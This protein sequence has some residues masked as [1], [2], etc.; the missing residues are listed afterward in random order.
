MNYFTQF[1]K[2]S[3]PTKQKKTASNLFNSIVTNYIEPEN[4]KT[5][6]NKIYNR[7]D[8]FFQHVS[9]EILASDC[10]N[11]YRHNLLY[12]VEEGWK[13]EKSKTTITSKFLQTNL[14]DTNANC[15]MKKKYEIHEHTNVRQFCIDR[16]LSNLYK[17]STKIY[18]IITN[19]V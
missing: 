15:K 16:L 2:L 17:C 11:K 14:G 3:R 19:Y 7:I 6:F 12:S 4:T 1:F 13:F 8:E 9:T 18:I 10:K 5:H